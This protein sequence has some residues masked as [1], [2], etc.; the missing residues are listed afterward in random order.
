MPLG[1]SDEM[2]DPGPAL[3]PVAAAAACA[4]FA[5]L[6][7][8]E[9]PGLPTRTTTFALL[10]VVCVVIADAFDGGVPFEDAALPAGATPFV[11]SLADVV[12]ALLVWPTDASFP[13]CPTRTV[14]SPLD[15][16]AWFAVAPLVTVC[17]AEL[18]VLP[19]AAGGVE[20]AE[21]LEAGAPEASPLVVAGGAVAVALE[22]EVVPPLL[23]EVEDELPE[24]PVPDDAAL[25]PLWAWSGVP[26]LTCAFPGVPGPC[27]CEL[28]V[29]P[30]A[31]VTCCVVAPPAWVF[32]CV[33]ARAAGDERSMARP[34]AET[35]IKPPPALFTQL[36]RPMALP[37]DRVRSSRSCV[38][39]HDSAATLR[40]GMST[41]AKHVRY[42]CFRTFDH[43]GAI[44]RE[45]T[46]TCAGDVRS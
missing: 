35:A 9:S 38:L 31:A 8:P 19:A 34:T 13:P 40:D 4:S 6:A 37:A 16:A 14:A 36:R 27:A 11:A 25:T 41:V 1:V 18:G 26:W 28:G 29:V 46:L 5:W 3:L 7:P 12:D 44:H 21:L 45:E 23:S 39:D 24:L 20:G 43:D 10:G 22:S 32:G 2:V 30:S 17:V 15:G 33:S 42:S